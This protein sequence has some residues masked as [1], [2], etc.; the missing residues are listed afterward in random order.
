MLTTV[1]KNEREKRE[2]DDNVGCIFIV[3]DWCKDSLRTSRLG[4]TG[5]PPA[6]I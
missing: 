5:Y 6:T 3:V 4:V 1:L 2:D